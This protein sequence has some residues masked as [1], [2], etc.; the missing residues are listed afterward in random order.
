VT[1]RLA[2]RMKDLGVVQQASTTILELGAALDD[3]L[4]KENRPSERMRMLRDTT[5]RIIRTANDAAQAYSRASRAIVAELE[6]PDT[7]PGAARD[8]R[9]RLDAARRDVM[10]ALEVAQQRYPPPDDAPSPESPQPEV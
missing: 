8:L 6:R 1:N 5:N 3:R 4:L 10:A 2:G 9:R 7:D